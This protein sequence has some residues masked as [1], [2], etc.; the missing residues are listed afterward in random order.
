[1]LPEA[2]LRATLP[3]LPRVGIHGPWSRA[4]QFH[5]LQGP[6]PSAP[7]G[8]P[9]QPLWPS[10]PAIYGARFT[11]RGGFPTVYLA[12][13][14][15]TALLE[16]EATLRNPFGPPFTLRTPPWTLFSVDGVLADVLDLTDIDIQS[17][18]GTNLA[19]LTGDWRVTASLGLAPPTHLLGQVAYDSRVVT[20]LVYASAKNTA[21]GIGVAVFADRLTRDGVSF[22]EVIDPNGQLVQRLP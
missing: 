14:P 17:R 8:S 19:E 10:G 12:S 4:L 16:V 21:Q 20:A 18:L 13:D 2:D 5:L 6:P 11:P 22:L 15:Y 9:P 3:H 1:M 7:Q